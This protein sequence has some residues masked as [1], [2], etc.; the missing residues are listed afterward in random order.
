MITVQSLSSTE[1]SLCCG[2]AGGK[3]KRVEESNGT[4][5]NVHTGIK[6]PTRAKM[7]PY[8]GMETLKY[9]TLSGNTYPSSSHMGV[10]ITP[11]VCN[12]RVHVY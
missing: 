1:A 5:S 10:P 4:L 9:H 11:W 6:A 7:I 8:L 3:K 12:Q 2:E